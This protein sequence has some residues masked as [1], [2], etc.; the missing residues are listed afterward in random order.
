[1]ITNR[2]RAVVGAQRVS[3]DWLRSISDR[4]NTGGGLA[5]RMS[6]AERRIVIES[7][8]GPRGLAVQH[9]N[10]NGHGN[11]KGAGEAPL[12][13][14]AHITSVRRRRTGP[15]GLTRREV[16]VLRLVSSGMTNRAV[17][18]AL[19]VTS[20]TVKFHLTN[21]YRKL[22]VGSRGEASAWAYENGVAERERRDSALDFG[23]R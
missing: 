15:G 12:E 22:G 10:G 11:G 16:E 9:G 18:C 8:V 21:V 2:G 20:E 3:I 17:A 5:F 13:P 6:I 14:V 1:M 19:W 4:T 23:A 7:D